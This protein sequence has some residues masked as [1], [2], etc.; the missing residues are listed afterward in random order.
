MNLKVTRYLIQIIPE[1]ETEEAYIEE[2]LGLRNGGDVVHLRRV[3]AAGFDCMVH[4]ETE[5]VEQAERR[6]DP[7]A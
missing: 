5:T 7:P 2:V 4:L 3:D 6:R 1:N